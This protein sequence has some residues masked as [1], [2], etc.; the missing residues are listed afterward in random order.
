[1]TIDYTF[2]VLIEKDLNTPFEKIQPLEFKTAYEAVKCYENICDYG[3]AAHE[4]KATLIEPNGTIQT[5]SFK[6]A[7]ARFQ[8]RVNRVQV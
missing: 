1:M 4:L 6:T 5:K 7:G 2:I 3:F 8:D